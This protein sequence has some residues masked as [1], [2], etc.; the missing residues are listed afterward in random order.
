MCDTLKIAVAII[1]VGAILPLL[2][3]LLPLADGRQVERAISQA[4][5]TA[6][7]G[8]GVVM[9][10]PAYFS[11]L[12]KEIAA[13]RAEV[14]RLREAVLMAYRAGHHHTVNGGYQWCDPGGREVVEEII[15]EAVE[16]E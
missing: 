10:L 13:L 6:K 8:G 15:R 3:R 9:Y 7:G 16:E 11:D 2:L 5:C 12:A 4:A 1:V 14:E